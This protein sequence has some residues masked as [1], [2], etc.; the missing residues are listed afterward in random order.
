MNYS[1]LKKRESYDE[2]VATIENDQTKVKYPNRVA[3]QIMN[4]PYMKQVDGETLMDLQN[5][6]DRMSKQKMKELVLQEIAKQTATPYVELR[7]GGSPERMDAVM[8]EVSAIRASLEARDVDMRDTRAEVSEMLDAHTQTEQAKKQSM[9]NLTASFLRDTHQKYEPRAHEM[10]QAAAVQTMTTSTAEGG[11]QTTW[12]PE[13]ELE[14]HSKKTAELERQLVEAGKRERVASHM[15]KELIEHFENLQKFKQQAQEQQA[16]HESVAKEVRKR[17]PR[18]IQPG[19]AGSSWDVLQQRAIDVAQVKTGTN[20]AEMIQKVSK[21]EQD[22]VKVGNRKQRRKD[23]EAM[24]IALEPP[25]PSPAPA[26]A[27]NR[28]LGSLA[29]PNAGPPTALAPLVGAVPIKR[30]PEAESTEVKG[31][32]RR[33]GG[34]AEAAPKSNLLALGAPTSEAKPKNALLALGAPAPAPK[35]AP[36]PE[37]APKPAP[38][39]EAAPKPAPKSE[40]DDSGEKTEHGSKKDPNKKRSYWQ[41]KHI[42]YIVDQLALRGVRI[43]PSQ[44]TGRAEVFDVVKDKKVKQKVKKITKPE[45]LELLYQKMKI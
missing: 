5:Q 8:A 12:R 27:V 19:S 41:K 4:S 39:P 31:K 22:G 26:P 44:L 2:I 32:Q 18:V 10:A 6:Q 40:D 29:L 17:V 14:S 9:A 15:T 3:S 43:D 20:D 13:E 24:I 28:R 35:P 23:N 21:R 45:L 16:A 42:G 1:G 37:A 36:K 33:K 11:T 38:K 25:A 30:Q 7:A 34:G